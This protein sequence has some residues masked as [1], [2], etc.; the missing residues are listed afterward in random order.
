M[1]QH[2]TKWKSV[3]KAE[4][5]AAFGDWIGERAVY[6]FLDGDGVVLELYFHCL[7]GDMPWAIFSTPDHE[8]YFLLAT[9]MYPDFTREMVETTAAE[10]DAYTVKDGIF[11]LK[12]DAIGRA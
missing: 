6:A 7:I 9:W 5:V 10:V 4:H 2:S 11:R 12:S 8:R 1:T 3:T